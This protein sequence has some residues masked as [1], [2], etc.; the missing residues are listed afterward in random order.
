MYKYTKNN[1]LNY[2]EN[3]MY[4]DF[5]GKNFINDF[6]NSRKSFQNKLKDLIGSSN[7]KI[8]PLDIGIKFILF[9]LKKDQEKLN[10]HNS[11]NQYLRIL[12]RINQI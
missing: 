11:K 6:I 8:R 1:L 3:Y 4:S 7:H 9:N 2:K 5:E 12:I 10:I